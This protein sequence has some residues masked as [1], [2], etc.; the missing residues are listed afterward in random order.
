MTGF[1]TFERSDPSISADDLTFVT[2]KSRALGRRADITFYVPPNFT[3]AV[4]V[5]IV[6]SRLRRPAST[7]RVAV[8]V[9][10]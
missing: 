9:S 3:S 1:R 6:S 5:P 10:H 2:V 4:D 8:I 7:S